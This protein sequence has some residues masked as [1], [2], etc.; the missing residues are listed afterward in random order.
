M[1]HQ[2]E[3]HR[4]FR[5]INCSIGDETYSLEMSWIK[6]I[7]RF[8]RMRRNE[9][10]QVVNPAPPSVKNVFGWVTISD[11]N[12][13][14]FRLAMLL[15]RPARVLNTS[16]KKD[17]RIIVLQDKP[18]QEGNL[19]KP[20]AL[21]VDR[22][23]PVIQLSTDQ[24]TPLPSLLAQL[25]I[26][27]FQNVVRQDEQL[28]LLLQPK[29]F[30]PISPQP[31]HQKQSPATK[32]GKTGDS[33]SNGLT[34]PPSKKQK[35]SLE[36]DQSY[37][38]IMVFSAPSLQPGERKIS[39]GL[40]ISQITE[41]LRPLPP[42]PVPMAPPYLLGLVQWRNQPVPVI[43]LEAMLGMSSGKEKPR[44]EKKT[45]LLIAQGADHKTFIALY[46]NVDVRALK[47]PISYTSPQGSLKIK[48]QLT[49][50]IVELTDETLVIPDIQKILA[51]C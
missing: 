49:N 46:I 21:L 2:V 44:D 11:E 37:G 17:M 14:V 7:L 29:Q 27:S 8:E 34:V 5:I 3:S 48:H 47:L 43:N 31:H 45:R 13:P 26:D 39:F 32:S 50:A 18:D 24:L 51:I 12:I 20:W 36:G 42:I 1:L 4:P 19:T 6:S 40:S 16:S 30:N 9:F 38:R 10:D 15:K 28:N 23:S 35:I 25:K 22:V 33:T 41:I